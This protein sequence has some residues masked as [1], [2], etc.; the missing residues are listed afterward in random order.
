MVFPSVRTVCTEVLW[1]EG[2]TGDS[3]KGE[4]VVAGAWGSWDR[5]EGA[6]LL[7]GISKPLHI[8]IRNLGIVLGMTGSHWKGLIKGMTPSD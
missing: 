4:G 3:T 7:K 8:R 6:S 2:T 5:E 1:P